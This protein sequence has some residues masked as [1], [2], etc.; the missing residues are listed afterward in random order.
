MRATRAFVILSVMTSFVASVLAHK[1]HF[2]TTKPLFGLTAFFALVSMA[3]WAS[4]VH[5]NPFNFTLFAWFIGAV[6][7]YY[8]EFYAD[9]SRPYRLGYSFALNIIAGMLCLAASANSR[10]NG[11]NQQARIARAAPEQPARAINHPPPTRVLQPTA[12]AYTTVT[13]GTNAMDSS[14]DAPPPSYDQVMAGGSQ[15]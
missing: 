1:E 5:F 15:A 8:R 4:K 11:E 7:G 10:H 13:Y 6:Q 3:T 2:A 12:P 14:L 9:G